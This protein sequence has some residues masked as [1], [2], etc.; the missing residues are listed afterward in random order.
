MGQCIL[1]IESSCDE[2]A[3]AVYGPGGLVSNVVASQL[4]AHAVFGGVVPELASR[5]HLEALLPVVRAAL[6]DAGLTAGELAGV[7]V[8]HGP[9]LVGSLLVGVCAAKALALANDLP[10]YGINHL[11]GHL[12]SNYLE[13][14]AP[15][16]PHLTLIASGGHSD[17]ILVRDHGHYEVLGRARDDAAGEA[18]DKVGRLLGLPYPGGPRL[19][20]LAE[21]GDPQ[22]F[23]F[24]R[25]WLDGSPEFSFSGLKTAVVR[26]C[27]ELGAV[28]VADRL[29]DLCASFRQA[30]V[31]VLVRKSLGAAREQGVGHL[32][33]CGGVAA[34][35]GL[36]RALQEATVAAGLTLSL[37]PL[38]YC[39]DNAAMIACAG[40]HRS[41]R[42][43]P[44][45]LTLGVASGLPLPAPGAWAGREVA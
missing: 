45:A 9:G 8:A 30:V 43:G 40:Y 21:Q 7:A 31:E 15:P 26:V 38:R 28:G 27:E 25:A 37:P 24:P 29:A 1:G 5:M 42:G 6:A 36:R 12:Y 35:V 23:A 44:D 34:S 2:T 18:F 32:A 13:P 14:P 41:Q 11:E 22:A 19:D 10:L 3:A 33:V 39:T 4:A 20:Q 16:L 17:L